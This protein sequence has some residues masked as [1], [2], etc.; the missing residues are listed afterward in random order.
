ME[1]FVVKRKKEVQHKTLALS[2]F[3][4]NVKITPDGPGRGNE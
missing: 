3:R 1:V 4:K 2:S